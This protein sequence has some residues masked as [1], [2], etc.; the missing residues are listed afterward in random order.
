M[1]R[2]ATVEAGASDRKP[3]IRL[4]RISSRAYE[5]II[6]LSLL[7]PGHFLSHEKQEASVFLTDAPDETLQLRQ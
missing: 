4:A 6:S 3:H 2:G 1:L 5:Q 7:L